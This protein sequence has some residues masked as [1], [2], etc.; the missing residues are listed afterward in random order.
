MFP[1]R[2]DVFNAFLH[3]P[4]EKVKVVI[5]GQD[6]YHDDHQVFDSLTLLFRHMVCVFLLI[7]E[8][9]FLLHYVIFIQKFIT[10]WDMN[11]LNMGA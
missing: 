8:L 10:I 11:L 2:C 4:W 7:K 9:Q 3:C 5:I 6:P 1:P